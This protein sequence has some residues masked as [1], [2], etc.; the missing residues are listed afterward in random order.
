MA[1][2]MNCG[3][4]VRKG[5]MCKCYGMKKGRIAKAAS[6]VGAI[7]PKTKSLEVGSYKP[8]KPQL[9]GFGRKIVGHV[10]PTKTPTYD[11]VPDKGFKS[12]GVGNLEVGSYKS[13][14]NAGSVKK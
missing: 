2:C 13:N 6:D 14:P 11:T 3:E 8:G 4:N 1:R 9:D 5:A 10:T 7:E 12:V